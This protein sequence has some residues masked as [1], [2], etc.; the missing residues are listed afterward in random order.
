MILA[1]TRIAMSRMSARAR[2]PVRAERITQPQL[3][4]VARSGSMPSGAA[5]RAG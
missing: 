5:R 3:Q 1:R 2:E 4:V